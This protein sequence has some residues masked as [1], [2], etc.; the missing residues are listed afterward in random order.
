MKPCPKCGWMLKD[1][2]ASCSMCGHQLGGGA[3]MPAAP[4][5]A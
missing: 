5:P 3:P 1:T 4:P 2:D